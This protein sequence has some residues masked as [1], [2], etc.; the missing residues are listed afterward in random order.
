[1]MVAA[2]VTG[3]DVAITLGGQLGNFELNVMLPLIARIIPL[4]FRYLPL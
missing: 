3:N 1:M 4:S 2:Q